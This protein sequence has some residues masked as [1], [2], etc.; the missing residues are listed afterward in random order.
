VFLGSLGF[1]A[2]FMLFPIAMSHMAMPVNYP[3]WLAHKLVGT[4][5]KIA[6]PTLYWCLLCVLTMLPVLGCLGVIGGVFG[7]DILRFKA[8]IEKRAEIAAAKAYQP[9]RRDDPIPEEV[10]KIAEQTPPPVNAVR[11]IFPAL[12]W[13]MACGL[14]GFASV[15]NMRTN[16]HFAYYFRPELDL[17]AEEKQT[18][19]VPKAKAE[20]EEPESSSVSVVIGLATFSLVASIVRGMMSEEP[21]MYMA[22]GLI[23]FVLWIPV[24]GLW[25]IFEKAHEP[26]WATLVPVYREIVLARIAGKPVWWG[27]LLLVPGVNLVIWILLSIEIAREFGQSTGFGIGLGLASPVFVCIL[28]FG[29][30]KY[31]P[32]PA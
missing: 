7:G 24:A 30:Y 9:A 15:Y 17:I 10:T 11:L 23:S 5:G 12:V 8:A 2:T 6:A 27:L 31:G 4:F 25:R 13:V 14:F 20:E 29:K 19:Y 26:P 16:G 22:F 21:F 1:L 18:K 28:G 32:Q 3:G